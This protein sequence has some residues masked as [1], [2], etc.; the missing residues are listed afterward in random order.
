[1]QHRQRFCGSHV[2]GVIERIAAEAHHRRR[3]TG[4]AR[5]QFIDRRV[6]FRGLH[7]TAEE[8]VAVCLGRVDA[9]PGHH[10]IECTLG[11]HRTPERDGDH[12]GPETD[13]DLGRAEG[14]VMRGHDQ[15]ARQGQPEPPGQAVSPHLGHRRLAQRPELLEQPCQMAAPLVQL[16]VGIATHPGQVRSRTEGAVPGAG[17]HHNTHVGIG[18]GSG[19][20]VAHSAD[21]IPAESVAPLG[22]VDGERRHSVSHLM[23][24]FGLAGRRTV[25][26]GLRWVIRGGRHGCSG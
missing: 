17:Y 7:D 3:G 12:V 10:Q 23:E 15:V 18:S 22:S 13:V 21:H 8:P 20:R 6:Q 2:E 26:S 24:Q 14:G 5:C 19:H 11:W 1:M 16:D 25:S 9:P 4:E